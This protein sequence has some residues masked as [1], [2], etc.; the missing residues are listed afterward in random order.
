MAYPAASEPP[1]LIRGWRTMLMPDS[2][3]VSCVV[4]AKPER[5][6]SAWLDSDEH[7]HFTGSPADIEPGVGGEFSAW[8]GYI[9]GTTLEIEP[10]HRIVQAWR[11]T[12]FPADAPDS[13][14]EITFKMV[15]TGTEITLHHTN[16]P[17]GQGDEYR[18]GWEDYYFAPMM[19]YFG[20]DV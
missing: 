6:Y 13:R 10:S 14:V 3:I 5:V 1:L 7:S 8:D 12:D 16:I 20:P 18:Q 11:T 15:K 4:A 17:D 9:T 19:E 2:F